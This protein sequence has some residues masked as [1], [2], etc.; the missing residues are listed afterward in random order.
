ME[1]AKHQK[2][3]ADHHPTS[4]RMG[5]VK[6]ESPQS[7]R[8]N[9][10]ARLAGTSSLGQSH[11]HLSAKMNS[12]PQ[13]TAQRNLAHTINSSTYTPN[14]QTKVHEYR[15][16]N[17][18][19]ETH[20]HTSLTSQTQ[21]KQVH[22]NANVTGLPDDL[23]IGIEALSGTSLD[24]VRVH[25]DSSQP[26]QLNASAYAQGKDIYIG[27]GQEKHLPHETWHVTQQA[28]GRVR[29]TLQMK[30]GIAINDDEVLER[31]A[32]EMGQRALQ[33]SAQNIQLVNKNTPSIL[34]SSS[35]NPIQRHVLVGAMIKGQDNP[36]NIVPEA[37]TGFDHD[38]VFDPS[39]HRGDLSEAETGETFNWDTGDLN[40]RVENIRND[41]GF[42]EDDPNFVVVANVNTYKTPGFA[43]IPANHAEGHLYAFG[44]GWTLQYNLSPKEKKPNYSSDY[45]QVLSTWQHLPT[46][47]NAKLSEQN[48]AL[49]IQKASHVLR[50]LTKKYWQANKNFVIPHRGLRNN[51]LSKIAS[52]NIVSNMQQQLSE[53]DDSFVSILHLDDDLK[54]GDKSLVANMMKQGEQK[55]GEYEGKQNPVKRGVAFSAPGY[56]YEMENN[57]LE[58]TA[59]V[60]SH[61]AGRVVKD[62]YPSEPGL[63]VTYN[64]LEK[65]SVWSKFLLNAP[66]GEENPNLKKLKSYGRKQSRA[67]VESKEGRA[68][69]SQYAS[70]LASI[71]APES[72][73]AKYKIPIRGKEYVSVSM[74]SLVKSEIVDKGN[75][76]D[77]NTMSETDILNWI[78]TYIKR[79]R[80]HPA[81]GTSKSAKN[82]KE[83]VL[84]KV[85]KLVKNILDQEKSVEA[86]K[87]LI[88]NSLE[89]EENKWYQEVMKGS[90]EQSFEMQ[91][92]I[93]EENLS[94]DEEDE[95][96]HSEW[97]DEITN[98][99]YIEYGKDLDDLLDQP[100][101]MGYE[102]G[103]EPLE[104]YCQ[105]MLGGRALGFVDEEVILKIFESVPRSFLK[106]GATLFY[107]E[108]MWEVMRFGQSYENSYVFILSPC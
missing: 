18:A 97:M 10:L 76:K 53:K 38:K 27:P 90:S 41:A 82:F 85:A 99:A 59:S 104:F 4:Q 5:E 31:E 73:A 66:W 100:Y 70:Y 33:L 77:I 29:P 60:L 105:F 47:P 43:T 19:D 96:T 12:S 108:K 93:D 64:N 80:Y 89:G 75:P 106:K 52:K 61:I 15:G 6:Y 2:A 83:F 98:F 49:G 30:T 28:Q 56:I 7:E 48:P 78:E 67:R 20:E 1:T 11:R 21:R 26:A 57:L 44:N 37:W 36:A 81:G 16:E 17:M 95:I 102:E 91:D 22:S 50:Y 9:Q 51:V 58:Y 74:S 39:S 72:G 14:Q 3:S 13:I 34:P 32:D 86:K 46:D 107:E 45:N 79:N 23:K 101:M 62:S 68:F 55:A 88:R 24:D 103:L 63:M 8:I 71:G 94:D 87:A 69:A 92:E 40:S 54:M 35:K 84:P 42:E 65:E 25:Y